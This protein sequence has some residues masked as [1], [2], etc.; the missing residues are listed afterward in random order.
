MTV[1]LQ[2]PRRGGS[3]EVGNFIG[4]A[5]CPPGPGE[6]RQ[7][8]NP[9]D[10]EDQ[11]SVCADTSAAG[12]A[13]AISAAG[14]ALG[15]W[16]A[17]GPIAR[18]A[19]VQRAARIV[20]DRAAEFAGTIV[21]EHG[22]VAA[23]ARGEVA[24]AIEVLHYAAGAGRRLAGATLPADDPR[25][26]AFTRRAPIGVVGLITPWNF[27][28]A[29]PAWKIGPALVS[30]CTAVLKPSPLTP[31]TAALL[32]DSF[33]E[34]GLPAG[35][36]NLVLGDRLAG[37]AMVADERVA[38]ISFT[39]SLAVGRQIHQAGAPRFLRTQLE[40][41]GKNAALVLADADLDAAA[42][43]IVAGAFGQAG[44]RCSATSRVVVDAA[45]HDAL[46]HRLVE[47]AAALR[48]GPGTDPAAQL[49][50]LISEERL[51]SCLA[52][53]E[54]AVRDGAVV[55]TGGGRP[56]LP[57][58][59]GHF[60]QPT[61]LDGVQPSDWIAQE[62]LFGPVLSVISCSGP[63]D[64]LAI[65]NSVQYGMAAAV[66][67]RDVSLAFRMLEQVEVG[68]L[69]LNRPGVGAYPHLPH[70]GTKNSQYGPPEC[71]DQVWDFY[72]EW[73]SVCIS[74]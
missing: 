39:G 68:M 38:G 32:V 74:Y 53:I 49:G 37:E 8:A 46:V 27:P 43:A 40:M 67:T 56:V 14:R 48:I 35:V 20:E 1:L 59:R 51:V 2:P 23:E 9:A 33:A 73:R 41:G 4:G 26:L 30:G 45:V 71:S 18:G 12:V 52:G 72:T 28:L 44:Q 47:R 13:A 62:E 29:I 25:T 50:P 11:V 10:L 63:A 3:A 57:G 60:L 7:N 69:H 70:V 34:A 15:D 36:L 65:V 54:R 21:R 58:V 19:L 6:L 64:G 31:L 22:K 16:Q 5:W 24:R 61:V 17:L 66:F 42:D 55:R